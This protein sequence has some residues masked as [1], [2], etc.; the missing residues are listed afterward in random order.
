MAKQMNLGLDFGSSNTLVAF[1]DEI[2][3]KPSVA[4]IGEERRQPSVVILNDNQLEYGVAAKKR[5]HL[6]RSFRAFKML[7]AENDINHIQKYGYD[8]KYTPSL[9]TKDF[10]NFILESTLSRYKGDEINRL[11]ISVPEIWRE[12]ISTVDAI[13]MLSGICSAYE[14]VKEVKVISEPEAATAYFTYLYQKANKAHFE[15]HVLMIDYGGGTLDITL[16]EVTP[17]KDKKAVQIKTVARTGSG[18]NQSN[19]IGKA[20]IAYIEEVVKTIFTQKGLCENGIVKEKYKK[21]Y[22]M[23]LNSFETSLNLYG[24]KIRKYF[25]ENKN[26]VKHKSY[27]E[28][29]SP[30]YIEIDYNE[31]NI[32]YRT[33]YECYEK[34]IQGTLKESLVEIKRLIEESN[35]RLQIS[36]KINILSP[37]QDNF[38]IILVGGFSQFSLVEEQVKKF[39]KYNKSRD[40][41]FD[42]DY[43]TGEVRCDSIGLGGALVAQGIVQ[44]KTVAPFSIG[45]PV[46]NDHAFA[47]ITNKDIEYGKEY[48]I[49]DAIGEEMLFCGNNFKHLSINTT[50]NS[51]KTIHKEIKGELKDKLS[52][53]GSDDQLIKI[54]FSLSSNQMVNLHVYDYLN[55]ELKYKCELGKLR[56]IFE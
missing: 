14:Y 46:G 17:T 55:D 6:K 10:I 48:F 25:N 40:L 51:K 42:N 37:L 56:E 31:E 26:T 34:V 20:G 24:D 5:A 54:A 16:T 45:I 13:P 9:I 29:M 7:L 15:G 49:K 39:F 3:S 22:V 28:Q 27:E 53:F 35:E 52:Q 41:R 8:E 21:P 33:L 38:K 50:T 12:K 1:F 4:E 47:F 18:E 36:S 44:L 43:I 19:M 32:S 23:A 2:E 11:V 30:L